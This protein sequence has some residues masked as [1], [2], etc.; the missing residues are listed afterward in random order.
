MPSQIP[1]SKILSVQND[2]FLLKVL[3]IIINEEA[4]IIEK[5]LNSWAILLLTDYFGKTAIREGKYSVSNKVLQKLVLG[6]C[7]HFLLHWRLSIVFE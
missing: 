3:N 7:G 4:G 6:W 2:I 1:V 5:S